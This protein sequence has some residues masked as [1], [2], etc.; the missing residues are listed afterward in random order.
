MCAY[1]CLKLLASVEKHAY[2]LCIRFHSF[3]PPEGASFSLNIMFLIFNWK[4]CNKIKLFQLSVINYGSW[5]GNIWKLCWQGLYNYTSRDMYITQ[6]KNWLMK[7]KI[8]R[9]FQHS[10]NQTISNSKVVRWERLNIVYTLNN[11]II[12]ENTML[13]SFVT[14]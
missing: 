5:H 4:Y 6:D 8:E 14:V 2:S 11:L 13:L 10:L 12:Y 7:L 3:I 9:I 1:M